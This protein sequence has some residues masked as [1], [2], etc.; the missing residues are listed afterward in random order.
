MWFHVLWEFF[1]NE[2]R[3]C[4]LRYKDDIDVGWWDWVES[5]WPVVTG[6]IAWEVERYNDCCV[7]RE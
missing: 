6:V 4:A 3:V 2:C 1:V 5:V 7:K